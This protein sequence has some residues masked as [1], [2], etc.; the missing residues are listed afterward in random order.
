MAATIGNTVT[1]LP[2]TTLRNASVNGNNA[3]QAVSVNDPKIQIDRWI[4]FNPNPGFFPL[5]KTRQQLVNDVNSAQK[6][7]DADQQ[8][9]DK[10]Q[11]QVDGGGLIS[12][13]VQFQLDKAKQKLHGDQ[14]KLA[15]ANVALDQKDVDD[16]QAAVGDAE[17]AVQN[18]SNPFSRKLAMKQLEAAEKALVQRQDK[19]G[20]D[21]A[22]LDNLEW[23]DIQLPEPPNWPPVFYNGGFDPKMI[24]DRAAVQTN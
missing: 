7:V 2:Q 18:A 3:T 1:A 5:P 20:D 19:L 23:Q 16:A 12:F 15:K 6:T 24:E 21:Q 8:V 11:A 17:N 14:I 22:D 9:V 4:P 13:A 10:L